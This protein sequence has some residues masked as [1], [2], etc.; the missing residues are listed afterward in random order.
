MRHGIWLTLLLTM[1]AC[2]STPPA[3]QPPAE[4]EPPAPTYPD[5]G[6]KLQYQFPATHIETQK[7]TGEVL[8]SQCDKT[9][10]YVSVG[11]AEPISLHHIIVDATTHGVA[12][13]SNEQV[14]IRFVGES[15][16]T[17]SLHSRFVSVDVTTS[18][19]PKS[20]KT[21]STDFWNAV[22]T[23]FGFESHPFHAFVTGRAM[24]Q[25]G[26]RNTATTPQRLTDVGR[27]MEFYTGMTS[28]RE[29]L[30]HD[31]GLGMQWND[32]ARTLDPTIIETVELQAHPWSQMI[33]E[34]GQKPVIEP[35]A[36]VVPVDM[37]YLHFHDLRTFVKLGRE[38]DSWL[39]PLTQSFE[40]RGGNSHFVDA[41]ERQLVVERTGLSE[42][43]GHVATD[44]IALLVGDPFL[45]EGT[46][47]SLIFR[48]KNRTALTTAL[49]SFEANA[50]KARPDLDEARFKEG[51]HVIRRLFTPDGDIEQ[52]RVEVGDLLILSN[53]RGAIRHILGAIDGKVP[54]LADSG[55]FQ[56]LRTRYPFDVKAEDG[57]VFISDAFVA[58]AIS[59]RTKILAGRRVHAQA[60]LQA[61]QYG[62]LMFGWFEGRQPI[63]IGEVINAGYLTK[64]YL[65]HPDQKPITVDARGA[66]SAWGRVRLMTPLRDLDLGK[67]STS[68]KQA[69]DFFKS[70]YQNYWRAM[71]D[72]IGAQIR[73]SD[74]GSL[75]VDARMLPII[76]AS[77]YNELR[78]LVGEA[79]LV[80]DHAY[81]GLHWFAA[82]GQNAKLRR[83]LDSLGKDF[84]GGR[85]E[86]NW[87]GDWVA[88]GV[89]DRSGLQDFGIALSNTSRINQ[90]ELIRRFPVY[91]LVHLR[92]PAALGAVLTAL[93]TMTSD[94][95]PGMLDWGQV[96]PYKEQPIVR[97]GTT[98]SSRS[99]TGGED[100][101]L[102]YTTVNDVFI[103]AFE[104]TT[105]EIQIDA[106]MSGRY[107]KAAPK[108]DKNLSVTNDPATQGAVVADFGAGY[109]ATTLLN[110]IE[111]DSWKAQEHAVNNYEIL[112]RGV[113]GMQAK[114][115]R[116]KGLALLGEEPH[117]YHGGEFTLTNAGAKLSVY[118]QENPTF[119][120]AGSPVTELIQNLKL[121][122]MALEFEGEDAH[123]G[124]RARFNLT[125]KTPKK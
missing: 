45:R 32:E 62:I 74:D 119:P 115:L 88:A 69:Y 13:P 114:D 24:Q 96:E 10:C 36:K 83:D 8:E 70:T 68:E 97:V 39:T 60:D 34:L 121:V 85:F 75:S 3:S 95:A 49:A 67:V 16:K 118:A 56:Y 51:E 98:E 107:A 30:Q 125:K 104:R 37:A 21:L 15:P 122:R 46:D 81:P 53:S 90:A 111:V 20:A 123:Q 1:A 28:V 43:L 116:D 2:S 27:T 66:Q 22:S 100:L 31:R 91:L 41:Y 12:V 101:G 38:L 40:N 94:S 93:K 26:T 80:T 33:A 108:P 52:N 19:T 61:V 6:A 89:M 57:F 64:D 109:L 86:L 55:D 117:H 77:D 65:K 124:I 102:L 105:L 79:R 48:V 54:T 106:V 44:G 25:I 35:M 71:I 110:I 72:P 17:F 112:A 29:A 103:V 18:N 9:H 76:N 42:T 99:M 87:L 92:N 84:L 58:N 113:P 82:I 23:R 73:H 63:E 120:V 50:R 4:V 47:V 78:E 7:T 14:L 59:P 11:L 5:E